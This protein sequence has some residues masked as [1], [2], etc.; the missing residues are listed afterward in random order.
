[1]K[2]IGFYY[3]DEDVNVFLHSFLS[4]LVYR[5]GKK[6]LLYSSS[7]EKLK[8]LD[9]ILWK[10]CGQADFLCHSIYDEKNGQ[11]KHEKI[12]LSSKFINSN[13]ADYLIMSNFVDRGDFMDSFEKGFYLCASLS[14]ESVERAKKSQ[15]K[16]NELGYSTVVRMRD[17]KACWKRVEYLELVESDKK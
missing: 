2:E 12:L 16:Y 11:A 17:E 15:Q 8:N 9:K 14:R 3:I 1:M 10:M 4:Q 5:N 7:I 13:G 6:V